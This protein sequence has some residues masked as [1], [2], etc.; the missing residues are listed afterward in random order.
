MPIPTEN[1]EMCDVKETFFSGATVLAKLLFSAAILS[2]CSSEDGGGRAGSGGLKT[3]IM[4]SGNP[5][6]DAAALSGS[7]AMLATAD[8]GKMSASQTFSKI[9]GKPKV[10]RGGENKSK[11][12]ASTSPSIRDNVPTFS[13]P[14]GMVQIYYRLEHFGGVG[15]A[16]SRKSFSD[17]PGVAITPNQLEP[18][19]KV[20]KSHLGE[21]GAV[22]ALPSENV[23]VITCPETSKNSVMQLMS[24]ADAS[25]KQVEI[26]VRIFEV[27][28]DFDL[29]VGMNTLA[30][31]LGGDNAQ[32]LMGNF[33]P[34]DFVGKAADPFKGIGP[35]PGGMLKLVG[36]FE[37]MGIGVDVTLEALERSGMVKVVSQPRMTVEAGHPAFMMAG[38]QLPIR[39]GNIT[40]DRFVTEKISYKPVGVQLSITPQTIGDNSV[41]LH[42][43]TVVSAVSG[44]APL[45][46]LKKSAY[47]ERLMNPVLDS[48][49][50]ETRVEVPHGSTLAFGGLRMARQVG[51]E[52][53]I[54]FLGNVPGLGNLFKSNRKQ[55]QMS[56][57]YFF[58]TPQLVSR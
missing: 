16:D 51:R 53:K 50:A 19:V 48:R 33:S 37:R 21:V 39:E 22:E 25:R 43:L 24:H 18:L 29:Q 28:D 47:D 58:V 13:R 11:N 2:S 38:Q 31:R 23:I 7:D 44:F 52:E 5:N 9:F 40:N 17:K 35:D 27:S 4:L 10:Y 14:D 30:K 42:V 32:A 15:V 20:V 12:T 34:A 46:K 49:Q 8:W 45:A 3:P 41:K 26:A 6:Q 1:I 54:P 36:A 55:Q 57:L 56:D